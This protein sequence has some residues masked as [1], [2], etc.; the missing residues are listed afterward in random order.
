MP[1]PYYFYY[2]SSVGQFKTGKVISPAVL[3]LFKVI[4]VFLRFLFAYETEN[5]LIRISE[6]LC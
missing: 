1:I 6:E 2:E 4:L 3:L 5:C